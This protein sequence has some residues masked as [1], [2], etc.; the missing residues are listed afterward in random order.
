MGKYRNNSITKKLAKKKDHF[1]ETANIK[2]PENRFVEC[3]RV[4]LCIPSIQCDF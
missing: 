4:E 1:Y 3:L 2:I